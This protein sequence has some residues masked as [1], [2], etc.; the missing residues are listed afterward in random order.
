MTT[1]YYDSEGVIQKIFVG[2][3]FLAAGNAPEN[4][5]ALETNLIPSPVD[6]YVD[7]N[8]ETPTIKQKPSLGVSANKTVASVN[9]VIVFSGLPEGT[10]VSHPG[11]TDIVTEELEWSSAIPGKFTLVF[12]KFPYVTQVFHVEID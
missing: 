3:A 9:E 6:D 11:G 4:T 8:E 2:P 1:V 7:V 10:Q 12:S 5:L